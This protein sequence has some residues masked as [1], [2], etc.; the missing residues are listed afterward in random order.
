MFLQ[1]LKPLKPVGAYNND[2]VS[3]PFPEGTI[4][5]MSAIPPIGTKFQS[6]DKMGP[7]SQQNIQLN[8][9]V[10]GTLWF[11]FRPELKGY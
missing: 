9:P 1:M 8:A 2:N 11:D 7:Q 4:G 3:P 5:W 10:T 6:A